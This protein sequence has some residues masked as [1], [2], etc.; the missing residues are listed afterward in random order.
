MFEALTDMDGTGRLARVIQ[1]GRKKTSRK[2]TPPKDDGPESDTIVTA[3]KILELL[4]ELADLAALM[5]HQ[6]KWLNNTIREL[7]EFNDDK[8]NEKPIDPLDLHCGEHSFSREATLCEKFDVEEL[9]NLK[10]LMIMALSG[11]SLKK[12]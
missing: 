9:T 10:E 8:P 1:E 4:K 2:A 3:R 12:L 11:Q 7:K 6:P 5:P